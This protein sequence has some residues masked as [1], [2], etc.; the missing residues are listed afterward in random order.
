MFDR[1][2][3]FGDLQPSIC[4]SN[5]CPTP[6][7]LYA[8]RS[9]WEQHMR[10]QH[11]KLWRCPFDCCESMH[12]VDE[13]KEHI[14]S[15]HND[16]VSRQHLDS[17]LELCR[18]AEPTKACGR[19]ILCNHQLVSDKLN[20]SQV[21]SH[22]EQ[23]ALHA[24]PLLDYDHDQNIDGCEEVDNQ[25]DDD[26]SSNTNGESE[27]EESDQGQVNT[28]DNDEYAVPEESAG[29]KEDPKDLPAQ[30]GW[31]QSFNVKIL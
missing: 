1:R 8:R 24:L 23:L 26:K 21:A 10:L 28:D 4:L 27:E 13:F 30:S 17:L 29:G 3:V 18:V 2:H 7:R 31:S 19:C 6:N 14:A 15:R 20:I 16:E 11:W 22:L 12:Q 9:D 25:I 5:N